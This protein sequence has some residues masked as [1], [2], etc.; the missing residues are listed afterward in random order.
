METVL[1]IIAILISV[2]ALFTTIGSNRERREFQL[3]QSLRDHLSR[4]HTL[5]NSYQSAPST[6]EMLIIDLSRIPATVDISEARQVLQ[7]F[8]DTLHNIVAKA[9][10]TLSKM[11]SLDTRQFLTP[12]RSASIHAAA[13]EIDE[14]EQLAIGTDSKLARIMERISKLASAI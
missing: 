3:L 7:D 4:L 10:Y 8:R 2:W 9:D 5:R 1:S 14:L 11:K 12:E 13:I 6:T